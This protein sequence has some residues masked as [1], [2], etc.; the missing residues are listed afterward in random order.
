[1]TDR[2]IEEIDADDAAHAELGEEERGRALP[3]DAPEADALEQA[4]PAVPTDEEPSEVGAAH[5]AADV[6]EADA[7]EQAR[8]ADGDD[9]YER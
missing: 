7:L 4:T 5:L 9:D 3:A 8:G 6:P 1:V 2:P